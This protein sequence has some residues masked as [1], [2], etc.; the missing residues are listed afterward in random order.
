MSI[1]KLKQNPDE[2]KS[3]NSGITQYQTRQIAPTRDVTTTNF[4]NGTQYYKWNLAGN[5]WW[6]P[7]RSYFRIRAKLTK[8]DGVTPLTLSDNIAPNQN[9]A[10]HLF[11]SCEFRIG[12]TPVSR[13]DNRVP[14]VDALKTRLNKSSAWLRTIGDSLNFTEDSFKLRQNAVCSDG[15]IINEQTGSG[16]LSTSKTDLGFGPNATVEL[17]NAN[18]QIIIDNTIASGGGNGA[19]IGASFRPGD[20]LELAGVGGSGFF[21]VNSIALSGGDQIITLTVT[22][23]LVDSVAA[24]R[25]FNRIRPFAI[26]T[27]N[28]RRVSSFELIY[29]P[30]LGIFD[31]EGALPCGDY[32]LAMQPLSDSLLKQSV[33]ESIGANKQHGTDYKFEIQDCYFYIS[34]IEGPR[35]DSLSYLLDLEQIRLTT[36]KIASASFS[37]RQ[38]DVSQ[39]TRAIACAFQDGRAGSGTDTRISA[40]KFKSYVGNAVDPLDDSKDA[41]LFLNRMY[42]QYAGV[43]Y[44]NT[45][46]VD[47]NYDEKNFT[48][49]TTQRYVDTMI[50][51]G[52]AFDTG[53]SETLQE[54]QSNGAYYYNKIYRDASDASTRL[55]LYTQFRNAIDPDNM[56]ALVFDM[57]SSVARVTIHNGQVIN[58]ELTEA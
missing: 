42:Y 29:T 31:Y 5:R 8:S 37:Q 13:I 28:S 34:E 4:S 3:S 44:P 55:N 9:L 1:F 32:E 36:N 53:G 35:C 24:N 2:L 52:G 19:T 56:R 22:E 43:N 40:S 38:F 49:Q 25:T 16:K 39:S 15:S 54:W 6:L 45:S 41:G 23:T 50:Q 7:S 27:E 12:S 26:D 30:A 57:H 20:V 21:L 11:Q 51:S 17:K 10:S 14:Q 58:V 47:P 46:D 48:D 18:S 33:I